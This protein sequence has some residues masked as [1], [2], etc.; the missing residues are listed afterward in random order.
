MKALV[1]GGTG[2]VGGHLIDA[3]RAAGAAVTALVRS[4]E[5]A[6]R[7]ADHRVTIVVGDLFDYPALERAAQGQEVVFHVAGLLAARRE[8]ELL[9]VNREGTRRLVQVAQR[10]GIRRLVS[11]SSLA[12]GG[13]ASPEAPLVG[14]EPARPVTGY[15]RSKLAGEEAV[16]ASELAWTIVRPPVVYGPG[17]REMLRVFKAAGIGI[18]PVFGDGSQRLSLVYGPDLARALVAAALSDEAIGGVY[19]PAHPEILTS[20]S[21]IEAVGRAAGRRVRIVPLPEVVGRA[22][23][24]ITDAAARLAGRATLLNYD[25]ANEFFQPAWTCDPEPF[26]AATGWSAEHDLARGARETLA[27]YRAHGWL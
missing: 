9:E 25:K 4:P 24:R 6:R 16:R 10:A 2:F 19:Y 3:L 26:T 21:L 17:D 15:G 22:A 18:A 23:L 8:A 11:V 7:L 27:W 20:R 12:A 13:P 5:K 14:H 1:T